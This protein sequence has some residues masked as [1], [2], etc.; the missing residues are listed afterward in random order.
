MAAA[1]G[2]LTRLWPD[3]IVDVHA[4]YLVWPTSSNRLEAIGKLR[5][6]LVAE[7]TRWLAEMEPR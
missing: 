4:H 6:W 1:S 2:R 5:T 7:V 3:E